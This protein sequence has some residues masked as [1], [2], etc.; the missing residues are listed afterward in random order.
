L[1]EWGDVANV[2]DRAR[3]VISRWYEEE[4]IFQLWLWDDGPIRLTDSRVSEYAGHIN[5]CDEVLWSRREGGQTDIMLMRLVSG[6]ANRDGRITLADFAAGFGRGVTGP[7][8]EMRFC[9]GPT[10]DL[11]RDGD[12]DLH[13]FALMQAADVLPEHFERQVGCIAGPEPARDVCAA[14]AV[15]FDRDGDVDLKDFAG[16]QAVV[17]K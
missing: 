9:E 13:D 8:T 10:A 16:F 12:V 15:D 14:L 6:D 1:V 4:R 5:D 7:Q 2:N 17:A 11:Q 3:W